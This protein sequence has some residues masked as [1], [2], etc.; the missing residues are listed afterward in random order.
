M[1]PDAHTLRPEVGTKRAKGG[2]VVTVSAAHSSHR[3]RAA[4]TSSAHNCVREPERA[5]HGVCTVIFFP[6]LRTDFELAF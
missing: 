6:T 3:F 4:C 5:S 2:I 1:M